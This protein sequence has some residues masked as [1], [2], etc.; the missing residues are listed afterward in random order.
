MK[1]HSKPKEQPKKKG[2]LALFG[3]CTS[4]EDKSTE[5]ILPQSTNNENYGYSVTTPKPIAPSPTILSPTVLSPPIS[6]PTIPYNIQFS[7]STKPLQDQGHLIPEDKENLS[8][9]VLF[10]LN[11]K[12]SS[13]EPQS[14]KIQVP[15]VPIQGP[16]PQIQSPFTNIQAGNFNIP[17]VYH[18]MN[19]LK[20]RS[21]PV[22]F[23]LRVPPTPIST[24][25][26]QPRVTK[27]AT[28]EYNEDVDNE[29]L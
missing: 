12:T 4:E 28:K 8:N 6:S 1:L 29:V 2:L 24:S 21:V 16:Q 9:S 13:K 23:P 18:N 15:Q 27:P 25:Q 20:S 26:R 11:Q 22:M 7:C 10:G 17:T 19:F 3:C 14:I 5:L